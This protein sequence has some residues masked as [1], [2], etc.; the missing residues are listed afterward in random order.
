MWIICYILFKLQSPFFFFFFT[1]FHMQNLKWTLSI[2][3]VWDEGNAKILIKLVYRIIPMSL[4]AN[5]DMLFLIDFFY[6]ASIS[7]PIY[8]LPGQVEIH[9]PLFGIFRLLLDLYNLRKSL[10]R[11]QCRIRAAGISSSIR[12]CL[13]AKLQT[14]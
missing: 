7:R 14:L 11:C 3:Y 5:I 4:Q 12:I 9:L 8:I 2:Y 13:L 6:N 10:L 1:I